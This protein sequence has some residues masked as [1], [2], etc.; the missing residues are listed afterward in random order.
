MAFTANTSEGMQLSGQEFTRTYAEV[1]G[2]MKTLKS[3]M[4]ALRPRWTGQASTI[5]QNTMDNWGVEFDNIAKHLDTMADLLIGGAG[6]VEQ[7]EDQAI[8]Q[9]HFFK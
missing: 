3:E 5:F 8:Q 9:G 6:N 7:A 2:H 1:V 4:E